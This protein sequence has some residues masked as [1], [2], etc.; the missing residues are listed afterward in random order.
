MVFV[1]LF[2]S[3]FFLFWWRFKVDMN[4]KKF[5]VLWSQTADGDVTVQL[6][7]QNERH[8]YIHD[9]NLDSIQLEA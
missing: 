3:G 1:C 4:R 6:N 8:L 7:R 2:V 5:S 9:L